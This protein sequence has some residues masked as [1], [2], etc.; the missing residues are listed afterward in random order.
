M[1]QALLPKCAVS[2]FDF[3]FFLISEIIVPKKAFRFNEKGNIPCG[4]IRQDVPCN[5][6]QAALQIR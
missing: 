4:F 3:P 2:S 1:L 6:I 5:S